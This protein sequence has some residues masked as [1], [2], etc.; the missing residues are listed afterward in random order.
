MVTEHNAALATNDELKELLS[1]LLSALRAHITI[2][3]SYRNVSPELNHMLEMLRDP[4]ATATDEF[5]QGI[6]DSIMRY[7]KYIDLINAELEKRKC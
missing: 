5:V 3:D 7:K 6:N 1:L 4:A 2:R